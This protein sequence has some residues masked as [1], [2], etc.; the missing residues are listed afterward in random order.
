MNISKS[1]AVAGVAAWLASFAS[2]L[3]P[4][5]TEG[6]AVILAITGLM[7]LAASAVAHGRWAKESEMEIGRP[8]VE[9][10]VA[11]VAPIPDAARERMER[12]HAAIE[13]QFAEA[14]AETVPANL[15]II[16][17]KSGGARLTAK[18]R[19][20]YAAACQLCGISP[21]GVKTIDQLT[22]VRKMDAELMLQRLMDD[23]L[24]RLGA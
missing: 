23:S 2:A 9:F 1:L 11:R 6:V 15:A 3:T 18:G 5:V 4:A 16:D 22:K 14:V 7:L 21:E 19:E 10:S 12:E 8:E 17:E 13:A 24:T 20:A